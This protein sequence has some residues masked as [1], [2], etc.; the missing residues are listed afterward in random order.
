MTKS[1]Q[2]FSNLIHCCI[3]MDKFNYQLHRICQCASNAR[4]FE[5]PQKQQL[6]LLPKN[7]SKSIQRKLLVPSV[8]LRHFFGET[9]Q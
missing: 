8:D 7:G 2:I 3:S 9:V 5:V 4:F 6:S 1:F